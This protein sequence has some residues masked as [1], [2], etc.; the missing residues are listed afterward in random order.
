MATMARRTFLGTSAGSLALATTGGKVLASGDGLRLTPTQYGALLEQLTRDGRLAADSF[1]RGGVVEQLEQRMAAALGKESAVYFP[2]GT[3]ANHFAARVLAGDRRRVLIQAESHLYNDSGD[4]AQTLS[5]LH[6]VPLAAGKAWFSADDV[7]QHLERA[8]GS[9]VDVPIGAIVIESPVRRRQGEVFPFDE[10]RKVCA[11]ARD[12]G[13]G[14]HLDGAR[15]FLA[16]PYT[17]VGVREYAA[18][19]DT[20]YVSLYKYFNAPAGAILAGPRKL[21][22]NAYHTRRM[23]G[24]GINQSW[25]NAAVALQYF[26]GFDKRFAD[27]VKMSEKLK[28]ALQRNVAFTVGRVRNGTNVWTLALHTG[29]AAKFRLKL[30]E[31]GIDLP[32]PAADTFTLGVNE[33]W[34][35]SNG[36]RMAEAMNDAAR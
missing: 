15:L 5:N 10:M 36:D 27:A 20:V 1:S 33:S 22:D 32:T 26:E 4:C 7:H 34:T 16:P 8:K 31:Q 6:L 28:S 35:R 11:A 30:A 14:L 24:G 17:G 29:N 3:L 18:L 23:F 19:F 21:L 25:P 2:T 13:I 12:H 9:R